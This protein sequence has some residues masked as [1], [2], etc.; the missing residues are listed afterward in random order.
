MTSFRHNKGEFTEPIQMQLSKKPN[1]FC[2]FFIEFLESTC[3]FE[4][5]SKNE[6]HSLSI[7]DIS[8]S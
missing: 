4:H 5:F 3:H 7:S 1:T 2:C 8:D 6:P